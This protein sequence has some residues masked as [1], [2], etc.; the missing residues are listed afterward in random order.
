MAIAFSS[1]ELFASV[2]GGA[3]G[4]M[5]LFQLCF[6][7]LLLV[8]GY[9]LGSLLGLISIGLLL[10]AVIL[11]FLPSTTAS[12]IERAFDTE[13]LGISFASLFYGVAGLGYYSK[14]SEIFTDSLSMFEMPIRKPRQ[15]QENPET[16]MKRLESEIGQLQTLQRQLD[17]LKRRES[18]ELERIKYVVSLGG[19][20]PDYE[21]NRVKDAATQADHEV[22]RQKSAI[23]GIQRKLKNFQREK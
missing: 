18:K 21:Y 23:R 9:F 20:P 7:I 1:V 5:L 3:I 22:Y 2:A 12:A 4:G 10:A 14:L 6:V 11:P 16:L 17:D 19:T 13:I 8:M 15:S